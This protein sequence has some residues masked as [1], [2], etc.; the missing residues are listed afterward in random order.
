MLM[1]M[2][3]KMFDVK[4]PYHEIAFGRLFVVSGDLYLKQREGL[5][6]SIRRRNCSRKGLRS[7]TTLM[8]ATVSSNGSQRRWAASRRTR[9]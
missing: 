3:F 4:T 9:P 8:S 7:A 6:A 5:L 2:A 1:A